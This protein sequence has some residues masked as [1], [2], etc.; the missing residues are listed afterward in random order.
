MGKGQIDE[1]KI[2]YKG[3]AA[4][5][6]EMEKRNSGNSGPSALN[7]NPDNREPTD[8]HHTDINVSNKKVVE[9]ERDLYDIPTE[10]KVGSKL[11]EEIQ[12]N[13]ISMILLILVSIPIFNSSTWFDVVSTYDKGIEQ[14]AFFRHNSTQFDI[15]AA[16]FI[17]EMLALP[18]PIVFFE[19]EVNSTC[20][21]FP[22]DYPQ[23]YGQVPEVEDLRSDSINAIIDSNSNATAIYNITPTN[24]LSSQ[25]SIGRTLF[26][27]I[28][29]VISTMLFSR[30]V[31]MHALEPLENMITT[32]KNISNDPIHAIREIEQN[33]ILQ[34]DDA[35]A[36]ELEE[37]HR[38]EPIILEEM[39]IK[40]SE[41][42]VIGLG[43]A[44]TEL[45]AKNIE[46]HG[47]LNVMMPGKKI[48]GIFGF[49]DIRNFTDATE[50][51]QAQVMVFVN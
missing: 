18:E 35:L 19:V 39:I 49:C 48:M 46:N 12:K 31:E 28:L 17:P 16:I 15:E 2:E 24:I 51:L 23:Y 21:E 47:S 13:I 32:V 11:K 22:R 3:E 33:K 38:T 40:I 34:K 50:V 26:V 27:C 44:G 36:E 30:D 7:S 8:E 10:T 4:G 29:L 41:L 6:M 42:L 14:L 43:E 5:S 37:K 1:M 9:S 45:M 25:L 20:C